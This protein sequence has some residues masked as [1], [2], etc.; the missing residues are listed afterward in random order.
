MAE[1]KRAGVGSFAEMGSSAGVAGRLYPWQLVLL[2][3]LYILLAAGY[4]AVTPAATSVQHN[5]DENAHMQYVQ[6]LASGHLPVFTDVAHGYENHQ[7]PL[8]YALCAPVYLAT[9]GQGEASATRACRWVSLLLGIFL[10]LVTYRCILTLTPEQPNLA[11]GTAAFVGLLP[12][13]VAL[14]ASVT[15]DA[16]TTLVIAVA[17]WLLVSLVLTIQSGQDTAAVSRLALWLGLALGVGVWTKTLTL[18][19][20][21]TTLVTFLLLA[22]G[23]PELARRCARPAIIALGLGLLLGAPW[24]LRN[25]LLY[26]DPLAQHLLLVTLN[27]GESNTTMEVMVVIFHGVGG[28][29]A[30]VAQWAFASFWGGFD[31]MTLFWDQN[32][33]TSRPNFSHS[34]MP[35]YLC[36]LALCLISTVGLFVGRRRLMWDAGQRMALA[37][38]MAQIVFTVIAFLNYNVHFFQAQGR[39]L[40]PALLPLA[41]FFVLGFRALLP[42]PGWFPAFVGLLAAGLVA[43]NIYT[44]FGLLL[45]RF[46]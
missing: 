29:F 13:N 25:T 6:T 37:S 21:L 20:F 17:L 14:S 38:L 12:S 19:L 11:L 30:K 24:L 5:P 32:P 2:V 34:P 7:P 18:S 15:N 36:L 39:Y 44:L 23:G 33:Q 45:P 27:N 35:T 4:S 31:S 9:H 1:S 46:S 10:I 42:P 22:R 26:G 43:L 8:Y 41:F 28:Y 3:I 16:L 40:Y